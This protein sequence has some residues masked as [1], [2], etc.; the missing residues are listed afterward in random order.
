M[1]TSD[2]STETKPVSPSGFWGQPTVVKR[3]SEIVNASDNGPEVKQ[4]AIELRMGAEAYVTGGTGRIILDPT[5]GEVV[6]PPGQFGLLLTEEKVSI[7]L[8]AIGFISIKFGLKARG[9][10][11]VSGFHVDPGYSGWLTFSVYNAGPGPVTISRGKAVF[12]LWLSHLDCPTVPIDG[13][14]SKNNIGRGQTPKL[15][16]SLIMNLQGEI[17]SPGALKTKLDDL[18]K[19]FAKHETKLAVIITLAGALLVAMFTW[20]VTRLNQSSPATTGIVPGI[21]PTVALPQGVESPAAARGAIQPR[22]QLDAANHVALVDWDPVPNAVGYMIAY[23]IEL[24]PGKITVADFIVFQK[25]PAVFRVNDLTT[26]QKFLFAIA[27]IGAASADYQIAGTL[28][29]SP[30]QSAFSGVAP[31]P[32]NSVTPYVYFKPSGS[33]S[34]TGTMGF[35]WRSANFATTYRVEYQVR[36]QIALDWPSDPQSI[37]S[38]ETSSDKTSLE[39]RDVRRQPYRFRVVPIG[40]DGKDGPATAW[41]TG[42]I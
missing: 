42:G 36:D 32:E 23:Q 29:P 9:L 22:I 18:T 28:E 40:R 15:D 12:L 4:G 7:P 19:E 13:Y 31:V 20:T 35:Y 37:R 2:P 39:L 30:A 34:P 38:Q 11:N 5:A 25:P 6:I 16:D 1:T 41:Y 26:V 8:D 33:G 17:A 27:P 3:L 21:A 14:S 24:A 10:V